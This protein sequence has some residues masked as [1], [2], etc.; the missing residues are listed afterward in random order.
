MVTADAQSRVFGDA[1]PAL[2]YSVGALGLVNGDTLA[3][4]LATDATA[5]SVAGHLCDHPGN[6][7]QRPQSE[8]RHHICGGDSGGDA[9]VPPSHAQAAIPSASPFIVAA[10]D[11]TSPKLATINL[12]LPQSASAV[13]APPP[14]TPGPVATAAGPVHAD[15]HAPE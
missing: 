5:T 7:D 4:S 12:Q 10:A 14:A 1:N 9:V 8:L 11:A 15:R 3:G 6:A 2:T 13:I